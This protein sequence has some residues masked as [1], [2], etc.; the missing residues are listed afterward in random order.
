MKVHSKK[1]L[2]VLLAMM[3]ALGLMAPALAT[4]GTSVTKDT[5]IQ[6][7]KD[8]LIGKGVTVP[9]TTFTF[10]FRKPTEP[11]ATALKNDD[12][13]FHNFYLPQEAVAYPD[14]ADATMA[15]GGA[16]LNRDPDGTDEVLT[17][18]SAVIDLQ[19]ISWGSAGHYVYYA[20]EVNGGLDGMTYDAQEYRIKIYVINDASS[21]TGLSVDNVTVEK[22]DPDNNTWSKIDGTPNANKE[23][24]ADGCEDYVGNNFKFTNAYNKIVNKHPVNTNPTSG[25]TPLTG[26]TDYSEYAFKLTKDVSGASASQTYAFTYLVTVTLP[27]SYQATDFNLIPVQVNG[28][29]AKQINQASGVSTDGIDPTSSALTRAQMKPGTECMIHLKHGESFIIDSLP[30]GSEIVLSEQG[31][32][33]FAPSFSGKWGQLI[34]TAKIG[35]KAQGESLAV[36]GTIVVGEHGAYI[37]YTNTVKDISPTGIVISNLPYIL[38]VGISLAGIGFFT[39]SKKRRNS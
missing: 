31:E 13:L 9:D 15:Y 17:N 18:V 19:N 6:I 36:D 26:D 4:E 30:V 2:S 35:S 38:M 7:T 27:A 29:S 28:Y 34:T 22:Y 16:N 10:K 11:E 5:K 33:G 8:L 14:L 39:L 20:S 24:A 3:M 21:A 23:S 37:Q 1:L 32:K 12:P 25:D